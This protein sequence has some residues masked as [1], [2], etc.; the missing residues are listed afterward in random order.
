MQSQR[1][2]K[3]FLISLGNSNF[4]SSKEACIYVFHP[5]SPIQ[6][7]HSSERWVSY[8]CHSLKDGEH[9]EGGAIFTS[10]AR[11]SVFSNPRVEFRMQ[12]FALEGRVLTSDGSRPQS[13]QLQSYLTNAVGEVCAVGAIS[14]MLW[15]QRRRNLRAGWKTLAAIQLSQVCSVWLHYS[16]WDTKS[17]TVPFPNT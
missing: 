1:W 16:T 15:E 13:T 4:P 9:R 6:V 10:M 14:I 7:S 17:R 2:I 5:H 8:Y 12:I 3:M 11:E